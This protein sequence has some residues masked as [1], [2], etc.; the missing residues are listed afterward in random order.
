MRDKIYHMDKALLLSSLGQGISNVIEK[1]ETT[2]GIP[3]PSEISSE[4]REAT[5]GQFLLCKNNTETNLNIISPQMILHYFNLSC[6]CRCQSAKNS[7]LLTGVSSGKR[8]LK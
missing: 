3:S 2:L 5:R 1:A 4:T 8:T 7:T 6:W